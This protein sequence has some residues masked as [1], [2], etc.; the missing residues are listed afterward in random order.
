MKKSDARRRKPKTI[1]AASLKW[2]SP[3]ARGATR[4]RNNMTE[5]EYMLVGNMARARAALEIVQHIYA[6]DKWGVTEK[7]QKLL[8]STLYAIQERI[9]KMVKTKEGRP[10]K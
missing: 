8:A 4:R 6:D 7:E 9:S 10:P 5:T 2:F 1:L 3:A